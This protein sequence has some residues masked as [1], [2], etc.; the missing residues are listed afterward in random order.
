MSSATSPA[1]Y[2]IRPDSA[3]E[4]QA[5]HA[6]PAK[7]PFFSLPQP[8]K[9]LFEML[10]HHGT[11][12]VAGA[13]ALYSSD[14]AA[15]RGLETASGES[16]AKIVAAVQH[17]LLTPLDSED[18]RE[19]A[20]SLHRALRLQGKLNR[21]LR[22]AEGFGIGVP[23][24]ELLRLNA[25]AA[26]QLSDA[27]HQLMSTD[28]LNA[29]HDARRTVRSAKLVLRRW[30]GTLMR[31]ADAMQVLRAEQHRVAP[32][33]LFEHYGLTARALERIRFKNG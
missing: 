10:C 6:P 22:V 28:L 14:D 31:S 26:G 1:R 25:E 3:V 8:G 18:I 30:R 7:K 11:L 20:S 24:A 12:L 33:A 9:H 2:L 19:I 16:L 32:T 5:K 17:T 27:V 23:V 29:T 13:E 15:L 21:D 4:P